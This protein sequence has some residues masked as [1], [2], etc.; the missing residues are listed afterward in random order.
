MIVDDGGI[1]DPNE[2]A[3]EVY[4]TRDF[5]A[6]LVTHGVQINSF[7]YYLLGP[8]LTW[9]GFIVTPQYTGVGER[10]V[11]CL[12]EKINIQFRKVSAYCKKG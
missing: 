7:Y 1:Q 12:G 10:M 11:R 6:E 2:E 9:E 8:W 4:W 3:G 5:E